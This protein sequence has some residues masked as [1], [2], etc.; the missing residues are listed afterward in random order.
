MQ[1]DSHSQ[2]YLSQE[3]PLQFPELPLQ[4]NPEYLLERRF[5]QK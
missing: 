1:L 2:R 3:V 4:T 5:D